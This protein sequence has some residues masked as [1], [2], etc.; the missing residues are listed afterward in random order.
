VAFTLPIVGDLLQRLLAGRNEPRLCAW[1][2]RAQ[3]YDVEPCLMVID[4]AASRR[5]HHPEY[6]SPEHYAAAQ[7]YDPI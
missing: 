6:C 5:Q 1:G 2:R 4:P 7:E 3:E